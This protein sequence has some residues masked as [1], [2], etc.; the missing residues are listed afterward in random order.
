[1]VMRLKANTWF[2]LPVLAHNVATPG[3]DVTVY[4]NRT[5]ISR[6]SAELEYE[7]MV[8]EMGANPIAELN[9][10]VLKLPK[11]ISLELL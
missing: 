3:S 8:R 4:F 11:V 9:G 2:S 10:S 1:M 7:P 5:P 6:P